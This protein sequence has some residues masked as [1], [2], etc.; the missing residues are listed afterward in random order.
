MEDHQVSCDGAVVAKPVVAV[1]LTREELL[2]I[3]RNIRNPN[4]VKKLS[5]GLA[6]IAPLVRQYNKERKAARKG[7]CPVKCPC[8]C[9]DSGGADYGMHGGGHCKGVATDELKE[10]NG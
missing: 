2:L 9:H 7:P 3:Q 5:A 8:I 4:I 6:E 1:E 10:N